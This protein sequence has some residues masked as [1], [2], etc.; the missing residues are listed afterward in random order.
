MQSS[1]PSILAILQDYY[2]DISANLDQAMSKKKQTKQN[3]ANTHKKKKTKIHAKK[4]KQKQ[5]HSSLG[6]SGP[7]CAFGRN[8]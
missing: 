3:K 8:F 6:L 1:L 4:K 5:K 2:G 7:N